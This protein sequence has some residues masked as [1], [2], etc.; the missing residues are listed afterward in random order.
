MSIVFT[1]LN[2]HDAANDVSTDGRANV[3][4]SILRTDC[5]AIDATDP[6]ANI[7]SD[8]VTNTNP[9]CTPFRSTVDAAVSRAHRGAPCVTNT[10]SHICWPDDRTIDGTG[11]FESNGASIH[12]CPNCRTHGYPHDF[13]PDNAANIPPQSIADMLRSYTI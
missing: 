11:V 6:T 12:V 4:G 9:D 8:T 5:S 13:H 10:V 3:H 7:C 2:P 1:N